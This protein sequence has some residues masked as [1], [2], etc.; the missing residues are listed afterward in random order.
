MHMA[1]ALLSPGVGGLMTAVSVGAM[2]YSCAKMKGTDGEG[3]GESRV[4]VMGVMGAF[5]FAAQMINFTIPATGSSGHI[6]GGVLLAAMLGPYASL[7][8]IAAVLI[9]QCLFF[10]DGGLLALGCNIFNMGFFACFVAYPLI[11][12]PMVKGGLSQGR[13]TAASIVSVVLGLQ[14]GAFSVVLETLFSGVTELPFGTFVLLMQPIHLA[15]GVVEGIITAAVLCFVY[16]M[17][18]GLLD[19]YSP[20]QGEAAAR[21]E[22]SFGKTLLVL[23]ALAAAIGGGLSLFASAYPDG[24]EWSMEKTAG[25]TEL[26]REG[27]AY[28]SAAS[29]QETT[30]FMPDYAFKSD[31]EY[32]SAL[33][34]STAGIVG[35]ALTLAL[36]CAAGAAVSAFKKR[37][38][39]NA[40]A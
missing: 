18:P 8:T 7:L 11:F 39:K 17:R 28:E 33:G 38:G 15:I 12:K 37:E 26:E 20:R 13:I 1:D 2:A 21:G 4:P 36:A 10:A 6:G 19:F 16:S 34:T 25:T 14:L 23:L 31:G 29:I 5:V 24:L 22:L 35:G 3:P 32:G 27:G 9:I 30:A 40:G